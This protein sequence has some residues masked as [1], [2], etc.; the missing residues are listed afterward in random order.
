MLPNLKKRPVYSVEKNYNISD[1]KSYYLHLH[2]KLFKNYS[3]KLIWQ[4]QQ[5]SVTE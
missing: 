3:K 1:V 2:L 4:L 5:I